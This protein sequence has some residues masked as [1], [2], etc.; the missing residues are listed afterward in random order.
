MNSWSHAGTDK[1]IGECGR[2]L[3]WTVKHPDPWQ[4]IRPTA[5]IYGYLGFCALLGTIKMMLMMMM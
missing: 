5:T 3:G 4:T 2:S 1:I